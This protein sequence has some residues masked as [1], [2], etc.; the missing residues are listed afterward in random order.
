MDFS[1]PYVVE[2]LGDI[3]LDFVYFDLEHGPMSEESCQEMIRAAELAGLTPLV[4]VPAGHS[5]VPQRLLDSGAMGIIAPH[6]NTKSQAIA[7]VDMVKFPPEGQRGIAGRSLSL[8]K[9]SVGDYVRKANEETMVIAMIEE[10]E[11]LDN[12]SDILTVAGLDVLFI[13]R[14]D[15]SLS[16]GIPGR[17]DD[18]LIEEAVD[19]VITQGRA[20]GKS[21]GVGAL[22]VADPDGIRKF[23]EKGARFF[24]LNTISILT[25]AAASLLKT[26]KAD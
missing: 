18:R 6:C 3:G 23:I 21:V 5:G 10:K 13:G 8:S 2:S 26:L 9:M 4:R 25:S 17:I 15:L 14:L 7:A 24:A 20:A 16:L 22:S 12:L 19:T 11:A 1:S